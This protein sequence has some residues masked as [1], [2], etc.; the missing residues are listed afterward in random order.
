[1]SPEAIAAAAEL[2]PKLSEQ[3]LFLSAV[4]LYSI[5]Q[6]IKKKIIRAIMQNVVALPI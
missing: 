5:N 6:S 2:A 1:M 4:I 3:S